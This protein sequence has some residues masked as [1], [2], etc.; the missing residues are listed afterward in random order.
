MEVFNACSHFYRKSRH[1]K[2]GNFLEL[3][4]RIKRDICGSL[5]CIAIPLMSSVISS[6]SLS[7]TLGLIPVY[8]K[9]T[10]VDA[11][12]SMDENCP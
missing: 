2:D 8:K 11:A 7:T 6:C 5:T 12:I 9:G 4:D 3:V 1:F 10:L